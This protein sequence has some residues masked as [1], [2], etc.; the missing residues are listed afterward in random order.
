MKKIKFVICYDGSHVNGWHGT[1]GVFVKNLLQDAF[2]KITQE[3]TIFYCCGRTDS[4]VHA[5]KQTVHCTYELII[6]IDKMKNAM[7]FYLPKFIRILQCDLVDNKF[8]SRF[9]SLYRKYMY[10]IY[11]S[12]ETNPFIENYAL[13]ISYD[14]NIKLMQSL[15]QQ[16]IGI[17]DFKSFCH[18]KYKGSTVKQ[19][20]NCYL[21]KGSDN[22]GNQTIELFFQSKSFAHHQIRNLVGG[23][24][25][26]GKGLWSI[27]DFFIVL[28]K[29]HR[30]FG[31]PMMQP[32][33][34]YFLES[35]Y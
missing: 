22:L 1:N 17:F 12:K 35:G 29:K 34:L 31:P 10:K 24:L 5:L 14:I 33:A 7:N 11:L 23:I 18:G 27:E 8:H 30:K 3:N 2:Y 13:R 20:D 6:S 21:E 4:G 15:M 9:S 25:Y 26:V 32:K 28:N 16:L 19:M